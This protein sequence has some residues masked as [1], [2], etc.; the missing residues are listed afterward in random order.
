MDEDEAKQDEMADRLSE[1]PG[2]AAQRRRRRERLMPAAA[3]ARAAFEEAT[4]P[5]QRRRL[6]R[7]RG[8]AVVVTVETA[9]WVRPLED[10]IV[11]RVLPAPRET[12]ARDG[13]DRREHLPSVGDESVGLAL[14]RGDNVVGNGHSPERH[15]PA[16]LVAAADMRIGVVAP[17]PAVLARAF[18]LA[19]R[20][21]VPRPLTTR[22]Y[23]ST[24]ASSARRRNSGAAA[25]SS[26]TL[27]RRSA[28]RRR[29]RGG[30][31]WQ[32]LGPKPHRASPIPAPC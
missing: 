1:P 16:A 20:G 14:A 21:R 32:S 6:R 7:A 29:L 26:M 28:E 5:E 2:S 24:S 11:G 25:E 9:A 23:N 19:L 31:T 10:H 8:L 18:K 17:T 30:K 13:S 15:L 4:T 22:T 3:L 12:F 27:L